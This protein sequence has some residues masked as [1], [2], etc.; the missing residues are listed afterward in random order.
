MAGDRAQAVGVEQ[1]PELRGRASEQARD[2]D[3][4]VSDLRQQGERA[5]EVDLS[6]GADGE[7]LDADPVCAG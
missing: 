7:E 6:Q 5:G 3:L 2:L 1:P 4:A